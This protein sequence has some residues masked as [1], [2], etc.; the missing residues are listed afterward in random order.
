MC[1]S[2]KCSGTLEH[3]G[4]LVAAVV[5]GPRR[6]WW[7]LWQCASCCSTTVFLGGAWSISIGNLSLDSQSCGLYPHDLLLVEDALGGIGGKPKKNRG[8]TL[9]GGARSGTLQGGPS[10]CLRV[11][12][13]PRTTAGPHAPQR[14]C[15]KIRSSLFTHGHRRHP[16]RAMKV[17]TVSRRSLGAGSLISPRSHR[18][19]KW[20]RTTR[21]MGS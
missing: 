7:S 8:P 5:T 6:E 21:N 12:G 16:R 11:C 19:P 17:T 10:V 4:D 9:R 15:G 18:R 1:C 13:E 20:K 3:V 2:L 14:L